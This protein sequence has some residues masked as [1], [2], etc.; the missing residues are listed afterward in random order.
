MVSTNPKGKLEPESG[1]L[2]V[3]WRPEVYTNSAWFSNFG[4]HPL[5]ANIG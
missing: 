5:T 2:Y 3:D 1:Y 4:G